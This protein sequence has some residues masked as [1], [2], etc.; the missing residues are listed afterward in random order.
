[1]KHAPLAAVPSAT[2]DLSASES[3][4]GTDRQCALERVVVCAPQQLWS[5]A[6]GSLLQGKEVARST[7]CVTSTNDL[8]ASMRQRTDV[9]VVFDLA[10]DD[11]AE[12]FEA[13]TYRADSTPILCVIPRTDIGRVARLL[14]LGAS[15]VVESDCEVDAFCRAVR[16]TAFGRL[17][18]PARQRFDVMETIRQ[19]Q[20]LRHNA[21]NDLARLTQRERE[22]LRQLAQGRRAD[23]IARQMLVS[24]H[25]VRACIRT[26]GGKLGVRGQL[27]LAAVGRDLFGAA[28]TAAG[29]PVH[30]ASTAQVAR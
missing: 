18:L 30:H 7:V 6:T 28:R 8:L 5:V 1:M 24:V 25:T 23:Q 20:G 19:H 3:L 10:Y 26:L 22:V 14:E 29:D 21:R 12:L 13:L 11:A 4:S 17:V 9:S 16:D 2:E 27:R 15:G